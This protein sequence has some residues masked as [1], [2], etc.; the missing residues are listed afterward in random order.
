MRWWCW[1]LWAFR[2]IFS[3]LRSTRSSR[4][5]S[6]IF[7][8][9][10]HFISKKQLL[11]RDGR[12]WYKFSRS[13]RMCL[14]AENVRLPP[15]FQELSAKL[16]RRVTS[17]FWIPDIRFFLQKVPNERQGLMAADSFLLQQGDQNDAFYA[18]QTILTIFFILTVLTFLV[19]IFPNI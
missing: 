13:E 9:I 4:Q 2:C 10:T 5:R 7:K 12:V 16:F 18:V 15:Q 6:Y 8:I 14:F 1:H 3:S 17:K 19:A 11:H